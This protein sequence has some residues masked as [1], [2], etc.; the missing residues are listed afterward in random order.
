MLP[1]FL[2]HGWVLKFANFVRFLGGNRITFLF[3]H[4]NHLDF[5]KHLGIITDTDSSFIHEQYISMNYLSEILLL[6]FNILRFY[7]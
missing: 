2:S 7:T 1:T 5:R 4:V 6:G 3:D